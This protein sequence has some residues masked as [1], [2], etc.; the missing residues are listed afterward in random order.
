MSALI[1]VIDRCLFACGTALATVFVVAWFV[2]LAI[3]SACVLGDDSIE[4]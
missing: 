3:W 1:K 4:D 2:L